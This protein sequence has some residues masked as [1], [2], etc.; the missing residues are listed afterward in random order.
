MS[1]L[2]RLLLVGNFLSAVGQNRAMIEDLAER[3]RDFASMVIC[4]SPYRIGWIRGAHML[5]AAVYRCREYDLAVIDLYSGRAFI[6]GEALSLFLASL[7]RPFVLVLRGG[8][9]PDYARR[10][11][12]RVKA[13]LARASAII[14]PSRYLMEQMRPYRAD[15]C[16]VPNPLNV[17][18]YAFRLREEPQPHLVWLRAF[19]EM[20]NPLLALQVGA[21]LAVDFPDMRLTMVGPDK[22]D[23]SLRRLQRLIVELDFADRIT[24]VDGVPKTQISYWMNR[25]DIFLNTTSVDNTPVSVLEAMA[26]GLCVVSTNVGGIPYLLEHEH[27][28]LLVTP[29]NPEAMAGAVRHILTAPGLAK[30]LSYN[31]HR[32]AGQFDWSVILPQWVTLL[33]SVAAEDTV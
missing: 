17:S 4:V 29:G 19:H 20:Y 7:R 18:A 23:G 32:K 22:G 14:T 27:D 31:A 3:L 24:L 8:A 5:S 15:L 12:Q 21:L 16:L 30:R 11:P 2:P 9:L 13:C 26:C 1:Q 28:T 6:W 33:T 25:G 10:Y